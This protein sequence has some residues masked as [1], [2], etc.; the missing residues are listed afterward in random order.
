MEVAA[1][2][3]AAVAL[4]GLR[5]GF[6]YYLVPIIALP[7]TA[8]GGKHSRIVPC[9]ASGAGVVLEVE[10]ASAGE[11]VQALQRLLAPEGAPARAARRIREAYAPLDGAQAVAGLLA[12]RASGR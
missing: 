6:Q 12:Q 5:S 9:L 10:R 3:V 2:A 1:H 8:G 4:L 11:L 7:S